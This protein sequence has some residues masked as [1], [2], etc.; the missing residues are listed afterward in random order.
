[1]P[2]IEVF[3]SRNDFIEL[4]TKKAQHNCNI[5]GV[6]VKFTADW[7]APCQ[8]IKDH[9]DKLFNELPPEVQGCNL[10]VDDNFDLYANMKRLRQLTGIPTIMY[11]NKLN[12]SLIPDLTVVGTDIKEID[13][14]FAFAIKNC[15]K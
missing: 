2:I 6:I 8:K 5:D 3:E 13:N 11:F 1:M 10:D 9:V 12:D 7:C 15:V 14:L 4:L